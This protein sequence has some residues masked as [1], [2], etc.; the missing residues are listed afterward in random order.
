MKEKE[1]GPDLSCRTLNITVSLGNM[2][3]S[4]LQKNSKDAFKDSRKFKV[5]F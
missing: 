2:H 3:V 4:H 1:Q 5:F